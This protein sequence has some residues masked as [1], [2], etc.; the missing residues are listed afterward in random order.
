L[1]AETNV[2]FKQTGRIVNPDEL[3][4][5]E[6]R[7]AARASEPAKP[8]FDAGEIAERIATVR[9]VEFRGFH[10]RF[11][12]GTAEVALANEDQTWKRASTEHGLSRGQQKFLAVENF[13]PEVS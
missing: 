3:T 6:R 2:Q 7:V 11:L 13:L 12:S 4:F 9:L 10:E 8:S 1:R 5:V